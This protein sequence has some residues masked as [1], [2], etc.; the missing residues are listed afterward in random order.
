MKYQKHIRNN[1]KCHHLGYNAVQTVES[2]PTFQRSRQLILGPW[3]WRQYV[4]LKRWLAFNA[5]HG[6]I[7]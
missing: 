1:E 2:Q 4:L 6:V 3:R 5:L 7:S